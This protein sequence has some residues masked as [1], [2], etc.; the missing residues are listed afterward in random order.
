MARDKAS[1]AEDRPRRLEL[2]RG[3]PQPEDG[4]PGAGVAIAD[5]AE[6][7]GKVVREIPLTTLPGDDEDR[8]SRSG[9]PFPVR[10]AALVAVGA[11]VAAR[12]WHAARTR[13]ERMMRSAELSGDHETALAWAQQKEAER[14]SKGERRRDR[15][16]TF[17]AV[18]RATPWII[19]AVLAGPF[20]LGIF[21]AIARRSIW[22]VDEP[23]VWAAHIVAVAVEVISVSWTVAT[24][25]VP[26]AVVLALHHLGR[27]AG[28][29]A[30]SWAL[31]AKPEMQDRGIVLTADT[32]VLAL[33][34]IQVS[35]LGK[36]F[37]DGWVPTFETTPVRDGRGYHTVFS[38]PLGVTPDMIAD[39]RKVLARNLH[40]DEIEVWPSAGPPGY[41]ALW[42]A[43]SGAVSK[44]APEY[45]LLHE[46]TAD[47]FQGVPGGVVAR[48]DDVLI[49][50][51]ANNG[52]FGGQM[53]QGKSNSARVVMLGCAL[54]PLC[55]LNVFVFANN[56]DFDAYRPRLARYV[57]GIED[58]TM[59]A[60]VEWLH[61]LYEE[62]GRREG[63]LAQ[64]GAKKVTRGLAE[65]HEDMR[66]VVGLMSECFPAGTMVG[67][68]PIEQVRAG[69]AVPSWDEKSGL[70]CTGT[71]RRT[72]RR[73]P[74][75][76]VRV[77]FSDGTT[78]DCTPEHPLM[79]SEG[80]RN[81]VTLSDST[82]V[83]SWSSHGQTDQDAPL[84]GQ[85][86][87]GDLL[88]VRD[89]FHD[90]GVLP[91]IPVEEREVGVLLAGLPD[92]QAPAV[93]RGNK[94]GRG[95]KSGHLAAH[96]G[97][98]SD[99]NR[100]NT[101]QDVGDPAGDRAQAAVSRGFG[102][103][104]DSSPAA[105]SGGAWLADGGHHPDQG[106]PH[107]RGDAAVLLGG[108][109]Q[110]GP[111]S[112]SG[113]GRRLAFP[114]GTAGEGRAPGCISSWL[115][116]DR[117]EVLEPGGDGRYGGVCPD[118]HVYNLEVERTHVYRVGDR[119]I[120]AH[121]CHELFGHAEYGPIATEL[122]TKTIKRAR[123][124]AVSLWF[125]TQSSRKEAIPP[126]LVELVSVNC[127]FYVKS[128]RSNDGFLGDG[129][130]AAG[131]RATELRPG[132]DRGTALIT[133]VSD[134]Q[135]DLV[136]WYFVAVDDDAGY[137]AATEVIGRA[138]RNVDQRTAIEAN[139][140]A[141][142]IEVRD[143]M[144][145]LAEVLAGDSGPVRLADL[146]PRLRKLAPGYPAYR[147]LTGI[148]LRHVLDA[149]D[150]RTT[151]TGNV[152]RLDPLDLRRAIGDGS[153]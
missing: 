75:S 139:S 110:P 65:A 36:A 34:H 119:G 49:P 29:L 17:V 97:P 32:V 140:A 7:T 16:E 129:A 19:G 118:G 141:P 137:D 145:D 113:S 138:M 10:H 98:Q 1:R 63:R 41:G 112:G 27:H 12:R 105:A 55:E 134:A 80:W 77:H 66:P 42:V 92:C 109:R 104:P 46:G 120:V 5:D 48:G 57:K 87:T 143:L 72:F 146:P 61:E 151:N 47:V 132:R 15:W 54:D 50:V 2:V 121:N 70:P 101:G 64:L 108:H 33:Q 149:D 60:A 148:E 128:W 86:G 123:K 78:L 79:T 127:C 150:V 26:V 103:R 23:Y 51:V 88:D 31:A 74:P 44:A 90:H 152:P 94:D 11:V 95:G 62:V 142:A 25:A 91:G 14:K 131:I 84:Q 81:A 9:M 67:A 56:G 153:E 30:P 53:G 13:H 69:D 45:P 22:A 43:D 100:G 130:F 4:A 89:G 40:R 93:G 6:L 107:Q 24:I 144:A 52:V 82:D 126:K 21:W 96:A 39:Q 59:Q 76:M 73:P 68:V 3:D 147:S 116:V 124:T 85:P 122:A 83:L 125:D 18:A 35:A 133:G 117:V 8:P 102:C 58:D 114:A 37:R 99:G 106:S 28:D 71:V 111:E 38:L 115:R 136:K 20:V 135:F